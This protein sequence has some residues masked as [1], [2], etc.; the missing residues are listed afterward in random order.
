MIRHSVAYPGDALCW[1]KLQQLIP[2]VPVAFQV[3]DLNLQKRQVSQDLKIFLINTQF[4]KKNVIILTVLIFYLK[5]T[6]K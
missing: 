5:K 1:T 3:S 2:G 6:V 4:E